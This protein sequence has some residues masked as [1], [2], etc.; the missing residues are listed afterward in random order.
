MDLNALGVFCFLD[1]LTGA[2]TG[3][4][5]RK[6]ERWGYGALWFA[7][8]T[9][10][11]SFSFASYLLSQTERLVVATG[12]AVVYAYEPIATMN[13]SRTLGE[14]FDARFLL[15][16]GVSNSRGNTRRGIPYDKPYTFMRAYLEKMRAAPYAA[17]APQHEPPIVLAGMMPK[18]LQLAATATHGTHTY[19][20]TREQIA[21][22]RTA[23][24]P[25]PWLCAELGVILESDAAKARAAARRYM[26]VYLS[27]DHYVKRLREIAFGDEDFVN[28]GSDRLVDALI[29][30]GS[31]TTIRDRIAAYTKAGASHVCILPLHPEGG[32]VP[33]ER[34]VAALAPRQ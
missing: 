2:Q 20:T 12:I 28:G 31:E 10:R 25:K 1:G 9:G 23:I 6:V 26:Q 30:W 29:A 34:A 24:G 22:I 16:L 13:A 27:V 11:E 4:F 32:M 3:A 18:M 15:G 14:L 17:P 8:T 19:F 5:V 33:D 7:E 21:R